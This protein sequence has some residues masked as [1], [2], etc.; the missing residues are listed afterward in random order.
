MEKRLVNDS[1]IKE[2]SKKAN[3][4]ISDSIWKMMKYTQ[5]ENNQ[6]K[7]MTLCMPVFIHLETLWKSDENTQLEV[8]DV[9]EELEVKLM[10]SLPPEYQFDSNDPSKVVLE[11]PAPNDESIYFETV[12]QFKCYVR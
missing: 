12:G 5:G 6:K 7:A 4:K 8:G 11:P 9:E 3:D 10:I 2:K 1:A